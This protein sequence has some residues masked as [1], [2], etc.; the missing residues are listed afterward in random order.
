VPLMTFWDAVIL[1]LIQGLTEFLPVSSSGHLVIG[2]ALLG[3]SSPGVS[4][5]IWL[6][7]GTLLAVLIYFRRRFIQILGGAFGGGDNQA[8]GR[9]RTMLGAIIV[10]TIPAIIAGLLFKST[11]EAIFDSP[12]FAAAMLIATG[13]ILLA[14]IW[15]KNRSRVINL[16]RGFI[17]GVAQMIAILPGISRSGSTIAGAMFMGIEPSAAAEFSFLLA[18]PIIALAFG[19]DVVFS[20]AA[21]F[22]SDVIWMYLIGATVAFGVGMLAIHYLLKI[23]RTGRFYLFG[24]YCLVAGAI[25][26]ILLR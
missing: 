18:A 13:L 14:T 7:F 21:L 8:I 6:H 12:R 19:Y 17:I 24:F 20:E 16:P 15:A 1:G 5:E 23:V 10:G 11:I 2:E 22:A 26:F 25:S 9:N 3:F 4:L